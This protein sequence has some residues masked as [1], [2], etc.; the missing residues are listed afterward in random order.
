MP[1]KVLKFELFIQKIGLKQQIFFCINQK[2]AAQ[3]YQLPLQPQ[4]NKLL[5]N[6]C[7]DFYF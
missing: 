5:P 3:K 7:F 4:W 1:H 2:R 6:L